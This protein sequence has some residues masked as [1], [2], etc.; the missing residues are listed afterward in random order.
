[1][2]IG[3][4]KPLK[5]SC[6]TF[7]LKSLFSLV[8]KEFSAVSRIVTRSDNSFISR[9]FEDSEMKFFEEVVLVPFRERD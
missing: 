5:E 2:F 8:I 1:M 4:S 7:L 9:S 3:E 6:T